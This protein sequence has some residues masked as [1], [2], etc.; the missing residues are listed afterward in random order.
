MSQLVSISVED[1]HEDAV[2]KLV[3]LIITEVAET[4][5]SESYFNWSMSIY[6]LGTIP[7]I[8]EYSV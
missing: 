6:T 1:F 2:R 3:S 7:N 4:K 8:S 5:Y